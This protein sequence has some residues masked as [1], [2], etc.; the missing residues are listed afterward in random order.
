MQMCLTPDIKKDEKIYINLKGKRF[1]LK[2][3]QNINIQNDEKK[4]R[5]LTPVGCRQLPNYTKPQNKQ[6][7]TNFTTHTPNAK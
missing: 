1:V 2:V 5:M 4:Q 6:I 3:K 7:M